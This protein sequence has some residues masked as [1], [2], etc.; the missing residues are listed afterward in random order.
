[1]EFQIHCQKCEQCHE[2]FKNGEKMFKTSYD[3]K[4]FCA[5]CMT[6]VTY[7]EFVYHNGIGYRVFQK[8]LPRG[9]EYG[10]YVLEDRYG[11]VTIQK[12]DSTTEFGKG[13][14][15]ECQKGRVSMWLSEKQ[16]G[17]WMQVSERYENTSSY[18]SLSIF[19]THI[20]ID[21]DGIAYGYSNSSE[22]DSSILTESLIEQKGIR[23]VLEDEMKSK[24]DLS[25][26]AKR[27]RNSLRDL[28]SKDLMTYCSSRVQGQ[29]LELRK[30]VYLI[31]QYLQ[32]VLK[33]K[34]FQAFNWFLTAPSGCGK[35]EFY[36]TL[37]Q[38]FVDHNIPIPVVQI[39]LSRITEEGFRGLDPSN[40]IDMIKNVQ[41]DTNGYAICFLDET[42]K[43]LISNYDGHGDNVNQNVQSTLLTL[44]EGIATD[45]DK[46]G[47][48]KEFDTCKTMF[49]FMGAFQDLRLERQQKMSR[50]HRVG[51]STDDE[52]ILTP[53]DSFYAPVTMEDIIRYGM[54]EELAGRIQQVIN[55][56][57]MSDESMLQLL[58]CKKIQIGEELGFNIE[59]TERAEHELLTISFGNLGLRHPINKIRE[60]VLNTVSEKFF[61]D[62]FANEITAVRMESLENATIIYHKK[63]AKHSQKK[64]RLDK[65]RNTTLES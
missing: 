36:R 43:K 24:Y 53:T 20:V 15:L 55:F 45:M 4:V 3:E 9:L 11:T 29:E 38:Y 13:T 14:Y 35:T 62:D 59:M 58:R 25:R 60:L 61:D 41:S 33:G 16:Q 63:T 21:R 64:K 56:K 57:R 27:V 54:Q 26:F 6:E 40:I 49:V 18:A 39:D 34:H 31:W 28:N 42:D 17:G 47:I 44:I 50:V 48:P 2:R 8:P 52:Q 65:E 32:S 19:A 23:S 5:I 30:A 7:S 10:V 37:K 12:T 1:M 51:F 46:D 22:I